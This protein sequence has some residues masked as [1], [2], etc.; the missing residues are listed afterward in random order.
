MTTRRN[1][2]GRTLS[3]VSLSTCV[4]ALLVACMPLNAEETGDAQKPAEEPQEQPWTFHRTVQLDKPDGEYAIDSVGDQSS[5]KLTGKIG[6]LKIGNISGKTQIDASQ[7]EASEI[8]VKGEISG[9][10][11]VKLN[12]P[13]GEV[14]FEGQIEGPVKLT[15]NAPG[16][17]VIFGS[18]GIPILSE[19]VEAT[20]TASILDI[21]GKV[22]GP[23][24]LAATITPGTTSFIRYESLEGPVQVTW[25]K[26]SNSDRDPE[27][28]EGGVTGE[29]SFRKVD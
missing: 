24:K 28:R 7:L 22:T 27:I 5:I 9:I 11:I 3:A 26:A 25:R 12:A 17:E 21:R 4:L 14:S 1:P 20:V 13:N 6:R 19:V 16:G 8:I 10:P 2:N 18:D 23:V 29:A 15:V